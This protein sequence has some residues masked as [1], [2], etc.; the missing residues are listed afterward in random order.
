MKY[1]L[2]QMKH[3]IRLEAETQGEAAGPR[4]ETQA[5]R[6]QGE[7]AKYLE[8]ALVAGRALSCERRVTQWNAHARWTWLGQVATCWKT[9]NT[10]NVRTD[11]EVMF[12]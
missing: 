12:V 6:P 10:W 4:L 11:H 9:R 5:A 1:K 8:I 3:V 2:V 7:V